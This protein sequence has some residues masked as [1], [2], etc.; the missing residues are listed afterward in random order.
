[1]WKGPGWK[2]YED[3]PG[4]EGNPGPTSSPFGLTSFDPHSEN[5]QSKQPNPLCVLGYAPAGLPVLSGPF[6]NM[7]RTSPEG[8]PQKNTS[9]SIQKK[10]G[11][12]KSTHTIYFTLPIYCHPPPKAL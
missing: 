8:E 3:G 12:P 4:Q 9:K 11:G 1:T 7:P 2:G 6:P 10:M 5:S